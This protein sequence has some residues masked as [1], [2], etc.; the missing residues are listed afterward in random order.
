[1]VAGGAQPAGC[2]VMLPQFQVGVREKLFSGLCI[3]HSPVSIEDDTGGRAGD[4]RGH[5][6]VGAGVAQSVSDTEFD[7]QRP[8]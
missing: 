2:G 4:G 5:T 7:S 8:H 3:V 1:M 6:D